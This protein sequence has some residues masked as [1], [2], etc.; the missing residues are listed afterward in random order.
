MFKKEESLV[1]AVAKKV[2]QQYADEISRLVNEKIYAVLEPFREKISEIDQKVRRVEEM[3]DERLKHYLK[4]LFESHSDHVVEQALSKALTRL[5]LGVVISKLKEI[6]QIMDKV[7]TIE[8]NLRTTNSNLEN[9]LDDLSRNVEEIEEKMNKAIQN[10]SLKVEEA[11]S[12]AVERIKENVVIDKTLLV[13]VFEEVASKELAKITESVNEAL[14]SYMD[15]FEQLKR[16]LTSKI[17][18]IRSELQSRLSEL[19]AR[20]GFA[21]GVETATTDEEERS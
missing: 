12:T 17:D 9:V 13:R 6:N 19:E 7:N 8:N 4:I 14:F 15:K 16:E 21:I 2:A 10:F 5:E 18:N 3:N 20:V 11:T 1:D